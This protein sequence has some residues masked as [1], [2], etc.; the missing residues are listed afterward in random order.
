MPEWKFGKYPTHNRT[1]DYLREHSYILPRLCQIDVR[2]GNIIEEIVN[3][4]Q[5]LTA[6]LYPH[7]SHADAYVVFHELRNLGPKNIIVAAAA[8]YWFNN[9]LIRTFG[10]SV[11]PI[12][13]QP[14]PE[15]GASDRSAGNAL[16]HLAHCVEKGANLIWAPEGTRG[17][18]GELNPG[19]AGLARISGRPVVP[20]VL[21]GLENSWPKGHPLPNLRAITGRQITVCFCPPINW[22]E[23]PNLTR[24]ENERA[25][26]EKLKQIYVQTYN[27]LK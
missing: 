26:L 15:K 22:S 14:R 3:S 10:N 4:G 24:K 25:F 21:H 8:D 7:T 17:G 20:I 19:I 12:F 18:N 11:M 6:A 2:G 16:V 13:P 23:D 5:S 1:Y 9:P 27:E